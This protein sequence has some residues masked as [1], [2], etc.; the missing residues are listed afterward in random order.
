MKLRILSGLAILG[1]ALL[2]LSAGAPSAAPAQTTGAGGYWLVLASTR[3]GDARAYSARPDGSRLTPLLRPRPALAPLDVSRNGQI[4]AFKDHRY[5]HTIYVSRA[6]GTRLHPVARGSNRSDIDSAVLSPDG[7]R[8]AFTS[9]R[10]IFVIGSEGRGRR[11]LAL[12]REPAWSPDGKAIAYVTAGRK[13]CDV[14]VQPLQGGGRVLAH[15]GCLSIL[16]P[17]VV[18][19]RPAGRL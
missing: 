19:G 6:D 4:V 5:P 17:E 7:K 3:D 12:G 2:A 10:G 11:R 1:G 8:L 9:G 15:G 13:R 16:G 14:A 18:A